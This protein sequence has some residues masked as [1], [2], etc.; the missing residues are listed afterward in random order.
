VHLGRYRGQLVAIK[1][2][3]VAEISPHAIAF[4]HSENAVSARF[5][6]PNI[7]RYHGLC[8]MPPHISLVFEYCDG[9]SLYRLLDRIRDARD[10]YVTVFGD[11]ALAAYGCTGKLSPATVAAG[12]VAGL[13]DLSSVDGHQ[14]TAMGLPNV[15]P[16][17]LSWRRRLR[18]AR[19]GA[20]ALAYMHGDWPGAGARVAVGG[21]PMYMHRDV[22]SQNFLVAGRSCH[23]KLSDF[24]ETKDYVPGRVEDG[25]IGTLQ[26][27]APE[28]VQ[29]LPYG[30]AVDIYSFGMVLWEL[31]T[32]DHPYRFVEE[33]RLEATICDGY[34]P[35]IPADCPAPYAALMR[36]CWHGDATRRPTAWAVEAEL[37]RMI[38]AEES[39]TRAGVGGGGRGSAGAGASS[40]GG[41]R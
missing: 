7:V 27:M 5:R 38:R 34:R 17:G 3:R 9:G 33:H 23:L 39:R 36:M 15:A 21:R 24:G 1:N 28:M 35:P 20:R 41:S 25:C 37:T 2:F 10:D 22:K 32:Y 31:L 8:V 29:G 4:F 12:A 18:M 11:A 16:P 26:W 30:P 40:L 6:H 14:L 19:D 13:A